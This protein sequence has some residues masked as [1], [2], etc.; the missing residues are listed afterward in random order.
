MRIRIECG[1]DSGSR[2][3]FWKNDR[4]GVRAV[5]TIQLFIIL[6]IILYNKFIIA[7]HNEINIPDIQYYSNSLP[8]GK[9]RLKKKVRIR[10]AY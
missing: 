7:L 5:R 8:V 4:A 2:A 1:L 6:F 10:S 9:G 3:R